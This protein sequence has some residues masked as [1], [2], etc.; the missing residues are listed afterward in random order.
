VP[1]SV[2]MVCLITGV[3]TSKNVQLIFSVESKQ[4]ET[5]LVFFAQTGNFRNTFDVFTVLGV[6]FN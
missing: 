2:L 4:I 1:V 3:V 5:N 6:W